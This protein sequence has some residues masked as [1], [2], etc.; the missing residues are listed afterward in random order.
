MIPKILHQV[1]LGQTSIPTKF[2]EWTEGWRTLHPDWEYFLWTEKEVKPIEDYLSK[3]KGFSSKSNVVRL[4]TVLQ[5]GGVYCDMD[6]EW[7]N[8]INELLHYPAFAARETQKVYCNAIFGAEP[9]NP[10]VS[11]QFRQL[12][13]Y[14]AEAP[15]WGPK[16]MTGACRKLPD[17]YQEVSTDKFYPYLWNSPY[18]PSSEFPQAFAVHHWEKSWR[19]LEDI[20]Q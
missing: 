8:N 2:L 19:N 6:F 13:K 10:W 16:L 7:N 9:N 18:R 15:P 17:S 3:C 1:W 5:H 4:W 20:T 12:P 14:L 11:Y